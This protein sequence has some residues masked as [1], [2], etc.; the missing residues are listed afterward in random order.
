[1]TVEANTALIR[2]YVAEVWNGGERDKLDEFLAPDYYDYS[3]TPPDRAGL[4][5]VLAVTD[6]AFPS[7]ETIIESIVGAGD[8]VAACETFRGVQTGQFRALPASGKGF[9]VARYRFFTV[10]EGKITSHRGLLDL[11]ALLRQIGAED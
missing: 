11:P 8:T 6:A 7:H 3:F 5:Q 2:R 9:A 1:M 4:A 10:A